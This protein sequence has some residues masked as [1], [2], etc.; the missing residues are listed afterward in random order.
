MRQLSSA[1]KL[2]TEVCGSSTLTVVF[3][4][5]LFECRCIPCILQGFQQFK[6]VGRDHR[7]DSF[8]VTSHDYSL[9]RVSGAIQHVSKVTTQIT[10]GHFSGLNGGGHGPKV[11][12]PI[13]LSQTKGTSGTISTFCTKER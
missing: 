5:C 4:D 9:A 6:I 2:F 12:L 1:E 10:G 7:S 13:P 3:C 11:R 8:A